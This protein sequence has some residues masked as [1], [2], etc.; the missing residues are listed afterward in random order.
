[1]GAGQYLMN[2]D[3]TGYGMAGSQYLRGNNN[4]YN[5]QEEDNWD[6]ESEESEQEDFT[7]CEERAEFRFENGAL[8][9]GQWKGN[10]RHGYGV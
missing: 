1:M 10:V 3:Q 6:Q 2:H 5:D 7:Q 9:K 8:Y 4:M